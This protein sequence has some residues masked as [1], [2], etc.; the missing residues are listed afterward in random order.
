MKNQKDRIL[1]DFLQKECDYSKFKIVDKSDMLSCFDKKF[2]VDE[3]ILDQL[4]SS[5]E[6]KGLIKIKYEDENVYCILL[7]KKEF[8]EKRENKSSLSLTYFLT[9]LTSFLGGFIGAI[10]AKII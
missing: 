1:L 2:Y 9:A 3:E 5:L 8:E 7:T 4:V 6:R 10:I